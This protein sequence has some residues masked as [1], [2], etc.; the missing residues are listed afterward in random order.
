MDK[1]M[2]NET[3]CDMA[4]MNGQPQLIPGVVRKAV[5]SLQPKPS[6]CIV[7]VIPKPY[8]QNG[9]IPGS[10]RPAASNVCY[11]KAPVAIV[12]APSTPCTTTGADQLT[13]RAVEEILRETR[14]GK[15]R[16]EER[17]STAWRPCPLRKPNKSFLNRTLELMVKHNARVKQNTTHRSLLKLTELVRKGNED[18][19]ERSSKQTKEKKRDRSKRKDKSH[20]TVIDLTTDSD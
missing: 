8:S 13:S 17:G 5:V 3:V 20:T 1:T 15:M 18:T 10:I 9:I 7:K 19:R 14:L 2:C 16:A 11:G 4:A 6:P 12:P